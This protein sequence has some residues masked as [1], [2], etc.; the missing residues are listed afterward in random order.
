M[1]NGLLRGVKRALEGLEKEADTLETLHAECQA[2]LLR[3]RK[4]HPGLQRLLRDSAGYAVFPSVGTAAAVLGGSFG[5][6][7]VFE[8]NALAGY[9]AVARVTI[10]LQ[11]GGDTARELVLLQD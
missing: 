11:V 8:G 10:G 6:G 5:M 1:K 2:T 7:E 3:M 4:R 9:A